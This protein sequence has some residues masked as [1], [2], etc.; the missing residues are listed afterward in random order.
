LTSFWTFQLIKCEQKRKKLEKNKEYFLSFIKENFK[1]MVENKYNIK[2]T[3]LNIRVFVNKGKNKFNILNLPFLIEEAF[4]KT[5]KLYFKADKNRPQGLVG[6]SAVNKECCY[7]LDFKSSNEDY[8]LNDFQISCVEH[9]SFAFCCPIIEQGGEVKAVICIDSSKESL[10][11]LDQNA[12]D[13]FKKDFRFFAKV[14]YN[15]L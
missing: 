13:E 2:L 10:H 4:T 7:C 12:V 5:E 11:D 3:E 15:V 1:K 9:L 8:H 14:V 6:R